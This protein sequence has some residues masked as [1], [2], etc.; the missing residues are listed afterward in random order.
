MIAQISK[1]Y[2]VYSYEM[3]VLNVDKLGHYS[4]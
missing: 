3:L 4:V 1:E 2:I